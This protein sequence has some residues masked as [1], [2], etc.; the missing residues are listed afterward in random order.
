V[1]SIQRQR[2]GDE[3]T[4][5]FAVLRHDQPAIE[6]RVNFGI[7]AGREVT[8]A[9]IDDLAEWLLD[10]AEAVTIVA[11]ERHEIGDL[12]EASVHQVR[13]E[14]TADR[15]PGDA[16]ERKQLEDRLVERADHWAR[17]CIAARH[18]ETP[19]L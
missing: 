16:L 3:P 15:V 5:A 17:Q 8:P 1:S 11:E 18:G 4:I 13:I 12:A 2:S 6:I 14:L 19:D 10:D 9:E 7:F